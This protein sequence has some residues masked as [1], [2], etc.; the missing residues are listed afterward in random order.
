MNVYTTSSIVAFILFGMGL[1]AMAAGGYN[2]FENR[3]SKS[4]RQMFLITVCIFFW[5]FGYAW[6]SLCFND[7]FAYVARAIAL[8]AVTFYMFFTLK[9]VANITEYSIKKLRIFLVAF[10]ISSLGAWIFI[11]QKNAVE[12]TVTP[13]GYW[14]SSRMTIARLV[15]FASVMAAIV[16]YYVILAYGIKNTYLERNKYIYKQFFWFGPILFAGYMLDTLIPTLFHIAAVPGSCI[17]AF[18]SAL[19]LFKVSQKNKVFGLSEANVSAYVFNDV[20]IPVIITDNKGFISLYN[21]YTLDYLS[22]KEE[23]LKG[24]RISDYFL[25]DREQ[26]VKVK[27]SD[28]ECKLEKTVVR[29]KFD[30]LLY[31]IYFV[32]DVTREQEA[33][34]IAEEN[35]AVAEEASKAKSNFLANMSHEI[36]T[37]MN[38]IIGMSKMLLDD[39]SLSEDTLSRV[40]DIHTAGT[41]LLGIINDILDISKI[42][43]GNYELVLEE[44]DIASLIND[45]TNI[46]DV[47]L[48]ESSVRFDIKMDSSVPIKLIGDVLRVRGILSNIIGNAVKFTKQGTITLNV[49][50][51][52]DEKTPTM[53]FDVTDTGIGI[54]QEDLE[55]IFDKFSQVDTKKNRGIQGTGLGLAISRN[56]ARLMD[57]DITV[58]SEY[59]KGSTFRISIKQTVEKYVPVGETV[60][61]ALEKHSYKTFEEKT[62]QEIALYPNAKVLVVDDTPINLKVATHLLKKYEMTVD[63]ATSGQEAIDMAR[64]NEYDIIF[65]DHMMPEMD[66]VEAARYIRDLSEKHRNMTIIALT[67]NATNEA[68]ELFEREGFQDFL[69]KPIEIKLLENMLSK[70][71]K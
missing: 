52:H 4:G 64:D 24:S 45:I 67:A 8:L 6:M 20:S 46:F 60:V 23:N 38:G 43:F 25:G 53:I 57:G 16:E 47:R 9:Y 71:L 5:D 42:E 56:L 12:F 34:R 32:Q 29:D 3:K 37:P 49:S 44:Y 1:L 58:S 11:I 70:W 2:S 27:D 31:T 48:N 59:G 21:K 62:E 40:N 39:K 51:D 10:L 65:M 15:Q 41:N 36:R 18:F 54:K 17:S 55:S 35:R 61:S 33:Y 66:G 30:A 14:Y 69:A 22:I 13:W 26:I 28:K 68:R 50:W 63:N 19:I 7:G